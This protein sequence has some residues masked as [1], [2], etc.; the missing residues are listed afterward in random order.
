VIYSKIICFQENP[1][2]FSSENFVVHECGQAARSVIQ[3]FFHRHEVEFHTG[4]E[5]TSNETIKQAVEAG[6]GIVSLHTIERELET[7][8]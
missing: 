7:T 1:L 4:I 3:R 5:M 8:R 2:A 6:M